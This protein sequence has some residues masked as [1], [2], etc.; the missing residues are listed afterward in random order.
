[1]IDISRK[2]FDIYVEFIRNP[3]VFEI[4]EEVRWYTN[5]DNTLFGVILFDIID[6]DYSA[7]FLKR[8][9]NKKVKYVD[10][11]TSFISISKAEE[12]INLM[13]DKVKRD[14]MQLESD[15]KD[16]IGVDLF[17]LVVDKSRIHPYFKAINEMP[18]H[19]A[20]KKLIAEITPHFIDV[21]GN[22]VEQFQTAGFNSRL[23]ELYLFCYFHEE[24]LKINREYDAPD[25]ILSNDNT[26][27]AVEAV[28]AENKTSYLEIDER[29]VPEYVDVEEETKNK[30]PLIYGSSLYSKLSHKTKDK[31]LHYWQYEHTKDIPFV[32]AIADFHDVFAMNISTTALINYLYGLKHSHYYDDNKDLVVVTEKIKSHIKENT[33]V[34]IPSGFFFQPEA[35]NISAII[36]SASGTISKFDRI[37]KQC[38]FD[39]NNTIMKRIVS[40]Y[41]PE[42]NA[43]KPLVFEYFVNEDCEE[44]WGEGISVYHNPTAL[45]PL[46]KDFFPS[47]T[48]HFMENGIIVTKN[49]ESHV[50][51]SFTY[52]ISNN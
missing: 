46:P 10:N 14:K 18:S 32:I 25:F 41:N 27:V 21:D 11:E 34:E 4:A 17:N 35:E 2:A 49:Y 50:Y 8:D 13:E 3:I 5:E 33:G 20:A 38:G 7:V 47:A 16:K 36:H 42:P 22:F 19:S 26:S 37:G 39:T 45:N 1:M 48:H 29:R 52:L 6:K 28:I 40:V 51:S 44:T 43:D 30:L 9:K 24:G 23:W 31:N 12:W 15:T